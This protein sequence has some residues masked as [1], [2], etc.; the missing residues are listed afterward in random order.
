MDLYAPPI[1]GIHKLDCQSLCVLEVLVDG[2]MT[3]ESWKMPEDEEEE[4][5]FL[6][7]EDLECDSPFSTS[8]LN[9]TAST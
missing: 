1:F 4:T 2:E 7:F 9:S 8:P 5:E 3:K 6:G